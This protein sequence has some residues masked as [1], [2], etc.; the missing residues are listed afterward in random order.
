MTCLSTELLELV[1]DRLPING[2]QEKNADFNFLVCNMELILPVVT[3][4][5]SGSGP[6]QAVTQGPAR[7]MSEVPALAHYTC[8]SDTWWVRGGWVR[9]EY[10]FG[11]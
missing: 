5:D 11:G 6:G 2:L 3:G 1:V 4:V 10:G 8:L 7:V 9:K